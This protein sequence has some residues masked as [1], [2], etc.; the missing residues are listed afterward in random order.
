[1]NSKKAKK[2]RK[3]V[4]KRVDENLGIGFQALSGIIRVRPKWIPKFIY[5][6]ALLPLFKIKY[7]KKIY[8]YME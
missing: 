4:R 6:L 8:K 7:I 5:I 1:M 2:F 3:V